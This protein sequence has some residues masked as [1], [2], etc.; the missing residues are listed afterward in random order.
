MRAA[1]LA[2]DLAV[3]ET[4]AA[5]L[6]QRLGGHPDAAVVLGTGLSTAADALGPAVARVDLAAIPGFPAFGAPGHRPHARLVEVAGRAVLVVLGR[7]HLYEGRRAGEVAHGVRTAVLAGCGTVVLTNAAGALDPAMAVGEP[8]LIADHLDL[9]GTA[10]P[11][12]GPAG[13]AVSGFVELT[14]AWSPRLRALAAAAHPGVRSGV[15]AQMR[16]PQFETPAEIRMLRA[17]GA[18]L[19]GMSTVVEAV[20]ARQLGAELLGVSAVTNLAAGTTAAA[21]PVEQVMA[22]GAAAGPG[23]GRLVRAVLAADT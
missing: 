12:V 3:A 4:A 17:L 21:V 22:A 11:L 15:Y 5:V 6:V 16:G 20:A 1:D 14:D 23:V 2:S 8:V 10:G 9:T 7:V 19:V 18:D 13:G